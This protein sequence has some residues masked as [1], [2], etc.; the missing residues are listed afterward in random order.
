MAS[1]LNN[2]YRKNV[3]DPC[4][5]MVIVKLTHSRLNQFTFVKQKHRGT[6]KQR[7]SYAKAQK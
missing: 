1:D 5:S 6:V 2:A 7:H 3:G 4:S